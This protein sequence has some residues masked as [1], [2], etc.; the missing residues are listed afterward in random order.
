M[1]G[2]DYCIIKLMYLY[3]LHVHASACTLHCMTIHCII[4]YMYMYIHAGCLIFFTKKNI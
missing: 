3:F 2:T 1:E 4:L